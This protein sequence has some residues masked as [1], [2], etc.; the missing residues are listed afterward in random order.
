MNIVPAHVGNA[1]IQKTVAFHMT[2]LHQL[3]PGILPH[4]PVHREQALLLESLDRPLRLLT[5]VAVGPF[6]AQRITETAEPHLYVYYLFASIATGYRPH[7]FQGTSFYDEPRLYRP[8]STNRTTHSQSATS[9]TR[10]FAAEGGT[11]FP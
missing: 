8:Q 3:C 4:H 10:R 9:W 11:R 5:E 2:G 6:P 1:K 7:P